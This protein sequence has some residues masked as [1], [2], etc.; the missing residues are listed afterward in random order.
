MLHRCTYHGLLLLPLRSARCCTAEAGQGGVLG[1]CCCPIPLEQALSQAKGGH[2]MGS[3][4]Q[5]RLSRM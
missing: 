2:V 1:C 3:R 5:R 4:A